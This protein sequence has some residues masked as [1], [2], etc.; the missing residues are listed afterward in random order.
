MKNLLTKT[1]FISLLFSAI[2]PIQALGPNYGQTPGSLMLQECRQAL[3]RLCYVGI[4]VAGFVAY[5]AYKSEKVKNYAKK[6][7][8]IIQNAWDNSSKRVHYG[9]S[10]LLAITAFYAGGVYR[11]KLPS[12]SE[13]P[14]LSEV[15]KASSLAWK[16][17]SPKVLFS[18]LQVGLFKE[19]A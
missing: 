1:L 4:V 13:M 2:A 5:K 18:A 7:K 8:S 12:P 16:L 9:V 17:K 15:K 19:S 3:T 6:A 11:G 10:T 14:S